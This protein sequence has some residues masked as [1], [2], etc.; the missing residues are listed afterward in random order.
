[1]ANVLEMLRQGV[2]STDPNPDG[3][4]TPADDAT[5][6]Y[7]FE[8][9]FVWRMQRGA[10]AGTWC[11]LCVK[12][13][14]KGVKRGARWWVWEQ[15]GVEEPGCSRHSRGRQR[16]A[17]LPLYK[18]MRRMCSGCGASQANYL[19]ARGDRAIC[20]ACAHAQ[21][22]YVPY[23][24]CVEC[25]CMGIQRNGRVVGGALLCVPHAKLRRV[26]L[27]VQR[28]KM[29]KRCV[30]VHQDD[31]RRWSSRNYGDADGARTLCARHAREAGTYAVKDPCALCQERSPPRL[32][33]SANVLLP[34]G[35]RCCRSC[36]HEHGLY[37]AGACE[38]CGAKRSATRS[39]RRNPLQLSQYVCSDK[40]YVRIMSGGST[41]GVRDEQ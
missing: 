37:T 31:P 7:K 6:T 18:S 14:S 30:E 13:Y 21:G 33:S 23:R 40:C 24:A 10:V 11:P 38:L 12:C 26:V 35:R 16:R 15:V 1:M 39:L 34:G 4:Q 32:P 9:N 3:G 29:C 41:E 27:P 22:V 5:F 28:G 2:E 20:G 19:N 36:A 17:R 25:S 8:D